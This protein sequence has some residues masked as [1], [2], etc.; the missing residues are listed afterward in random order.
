MQISV[1]PQILFERSFAFGFLSDDPWVTSLQFCPDGTVAG[2]EHPNE[3]RWLLD[4]DGLHFLNAA[5]EPT[6]T[7]SEME[8]RQDLISFHGLSLTAPD[9]GAP[10]VLTE[11]KTP[12]AMTAWHPPAPLVARDAVWEA[13]R[14]NAIFVRTHFWDEKVAELVAKLRTN[15]HVAD[16]L[17]LVDTTSG[18]IGLEINIDI[19]VVAFSEEAA[20]KIGFRQTKYPLFYD[21]GDISF[22]F[23]MRNRPA[24][25]YYI[26]L[27][28]DVDFPE[29]DASLFNDI[30]ALPNL[31]GL[32]FVGLMVTP[33]DPSVGW[34]PASAKRFSERYCFY[35]YFPF[36]MLSRRALS[37]MYSQRLIES[38]SETAAGDIVQCESFTPSSLRAG[39][40]SCADLNELLPGCYSWESTAHQLRPTGV[41]SP[42]SLRRS[43]DPSIRLVHPVYSCREYIFRVYQKFLVIR[44][45]D[46]DGLFRE[47]ES[48]EALSLPADM[49]KKFRDEMHQRW[50]D[51][52]AAS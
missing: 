39:G 24:Y 17:L 45:D 21:C 49:L 40:F 50:V 30:F 11:V 1:E 44:T 20:R 2:Y 16:I 33:Q 9:L 41:G 42:M 6:S 32:D 38:M 23:A 7:F 43:F 15:N 3:R 25:R 5:G 13:G 47:L 37:F 52:L 48:P 19:D 34:G 14:P 18:E 22:Y 36:V 27:D 12:E 51:H 35:S 4:G 26:F 29:N 31:D 46:Y 10:L 28:H 8:L